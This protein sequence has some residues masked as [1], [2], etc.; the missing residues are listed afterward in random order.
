MG[1]DGGIMHLHS[2]KKNRECVFYRVRYI[3]M[4]EVVAYLIS[5]EV[6]KEEEELWRRRNNDVL[7]EEEEDR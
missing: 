6:K 7:D 3:S 5:D 4:F 1:I 2:K